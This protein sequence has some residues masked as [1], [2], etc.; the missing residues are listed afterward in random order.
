MAVYN[1][2]TNSQFEYLNDVDRKAE[3][4]FDLFGRKLVDHQFC[5]VGCFKNAYID[6]AIIIGIRNRFG[7]LTIG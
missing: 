3:S 1:M 7:E 6:N 5:D 4:H 2:K